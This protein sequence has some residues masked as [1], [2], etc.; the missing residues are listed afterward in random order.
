M[1]PEKIGAGGRH[2]CPGGLED[3][4]VL[5]SINRMSKA[6][7]AN[8]KWQ[9]AAIVIGLIGAL[10]PV[11]VFAQDRKPDDCRPAAVASAGKQQLCDRQGPVQP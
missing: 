3:I 6:G 1:H 11:V 5:A 7:A 10:L 8:M 4:S 2:L 9:D